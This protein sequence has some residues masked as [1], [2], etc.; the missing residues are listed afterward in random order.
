MH[1]SLPFCHLKS[2]LWIHLKIS[3]TSLYTCATNIYLIELGK[4]WKF[5]ISPCTM[6]FMGISLGIFYIHVCIYAWFIIIAIVYFIFIFFVVLLTCRYT[7]CL[8]KNWSMDINKCGVDF[9]WR[10][11]NCLDPIVVECYEHIMRHLLN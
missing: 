4:K 1:K 10:L 3:T 5:F 7:P 6:I 11:V 2:T 9:Q 8:S